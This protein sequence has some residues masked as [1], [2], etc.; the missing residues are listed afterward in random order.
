[1]LSV[2]NEIHIVR[3]LLDR[4]RGSGVLIHS[5]GGRYFYTFTMSP[6]VLH[7]LSWPRLVKIANGQEPIPQENPD[8]TSTYRPRRARSRATA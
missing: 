5:R 7:R 8:A 1:M 4:V 3:R 2:E 6:D